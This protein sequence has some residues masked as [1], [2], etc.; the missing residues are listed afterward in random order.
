MRALNIRRFGGV[1]RK[2]LLDKIPIFN[3]LCAKLCTLAHG[4]RL[5]RQAFGAPGTRII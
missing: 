5:K 1:S 3:N 4:N 2:K